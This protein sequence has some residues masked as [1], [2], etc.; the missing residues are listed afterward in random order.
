MISNKQKAGAGIALLTLLSLGGVYIFD[1]NIGYA[2]GSTKKNQKFPDADFTVDN[3]GDL[4]DAINQFLS[5]IL[6]V[7]KTKRK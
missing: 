3:S 1:G 5:Y 4:E 6:S 7:V 2:P